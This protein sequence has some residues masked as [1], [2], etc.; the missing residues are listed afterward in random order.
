MGSGFVEGTAR[1]TLMLVCAASGFAVLNGTMVPV[2]LPVVG[3]DLYLSPD[4][5]GW[6]VTGYFLMYGIAI[7]FYGRLA[8]VYGIRRVFTTGVTIFA[9]GSLLCALAQS[10][11]IL[12]AARLLQAAGAAALSGLTPA[13]ISLTYPPSRRGRALGMVGATVGISAAAGPT[14]GGFITGFLGWHALFGLSTLAGGLIPLALRVLPVERTQDG[15][16]L[17]W[18]GGLLLGTSIAGVLLALT[19]GAKNGVGDPVSLSAATAAALAF[20]GLV[21]WQRR[22]ASPFLPRTLLENRDYVKLI[23]MSLGLIGINITIEFALPLVLTDLNG[24]S[25]EL[26]GLSLLPAALALAVSGPVSGWLVDRIGSPPPIR[27]GLILVILSL[28]AL[29]SFGA[30]AQVWVIGL[31]AVTINAGATLAK[32]ALSTSLSLTANRE[33]L[34]SGL[35]IGEMSFLLGAS[36]GTALFSTALSV[37]NSADSPIN[38]LF[39]GSA[40]AYSDGFL[41][42]AVPL[43]AVLLISLILRPTR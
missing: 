13:A 38:P 33:N 12:I 15:E 5:L 1:R 29:S 35:A 21:I 26:V 43:L 7:P 2:A 25:P 3:R 28:L 27:A 36:L 10:Y 22:A 37:R 16:R 8:D 32:I 11:P 20:A 40:V 9:L 41:L 31:L 14:L 39:A 42:L 17:D 4:I 6:I 34:S 24:L 30:G 23:V 19:E 18:P